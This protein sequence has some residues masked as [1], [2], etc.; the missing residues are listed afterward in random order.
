MDN[1]TTDTLT[2]A[3]ERVIDAPSAAVWRCWTEPSLLMQWYCP[4]PWQVT[5]ARMDVR[6]GGSF[7]AL[8]QGPEGEAIPVPGVYLAVEP[9]RRLVFTDA[10]TDAWRPSGKAFMV[11]EVLLE[12]TQDGKTRYRAMAHHWNAQDRDQHL[13]MGFEAGWNAAADQLE[14]LARSL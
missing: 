9:G 3:I 14:A 6:P 11:G 4:R 2:L 10:F 5:Q 7:F 1:K 8:M 13:Q 12:D